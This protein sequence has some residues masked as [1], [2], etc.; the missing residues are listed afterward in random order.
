M[1]KKAMN[2]KIVMMTTHLRNYKALRKYHSFSKLYI[3]LIFSFFVFFNGSQA[4]AVEKYEKTIN[5]AQQAIKSS[6][7]ISNKIKYLK[8]KNKKTG[9]KDKTNAESAFP[10]A[11]PFNISIKNKNL[12]EINIRIIDK[13]NA[14]AKKMTLFR[15]RLVKSGSLIFKV[16]GCLKNMDGNNQEYGYKAFIDI[17]ETNKST[18][19]ASLSEKP[20]DDNIDKIAD[21]KFSGWIFSALPSIS[22]IEHRVYDIRLLSC[23]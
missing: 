13:I 2:Q 1:T 11:T 21:I 16:S 17:W 15:N 18:A 22:H 14:V 19:N 6:E 12:S 20:N 9:T 5:K 3:F 4:K 10:L 8:N 23:L 7:E